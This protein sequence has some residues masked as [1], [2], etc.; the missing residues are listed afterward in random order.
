MR[1]VTSFLILMA[2]LYG[3]AGNF[4]I[5]V[6]NP[7]ELNLALLDIPSGC[8]TLS[9]TG[10]LN[11]ADLQLLH[12]GYGMLKSIHTLDVSGI[13]CIENEED[14][15]LTVNRVRYFFSSKEY[16]ELITEESN[17]WLVHDN[18]YT[19]YY[20]RSL[21][22]VFAIDAPYKEVI[23]PAYCNATKSAFYENTNIE[24]ISYTVAPTKVEDYAFYGCSALKNVNV[25][26]ELSE[27]GERAFMA[28]ENVIL[29]KL[30]PSVVGREA[31]AEANVTDM[32]FSK[33]LKLDDGAFMKSNL[34][35]EI[36]LSNI[37]TIP[38][39]CFKFAYNI[40]GVK[41]SPSLKW[42]DRE[43]LYGVNLGI[44]EFPE[45]LEYLGAQ[46][47]GDY[48]TRE[49]KLKPEDGIYYVANVAYALDFETLPTNIVIKAG[50]KAI[51]GDLFSGNWATEKAI[52]SVKLPEGLKHIGERAFDYAKSL[53]TIN[54]PE[55]LVGIYDEAFSSADKLMTPAFPS[56]LR[57]IGSR[58][59]QNCQMIT[60]LTLPSSIETIGDYAFEGCNGI[61]R[62]YFDIMD[63]SNCEFLLAGE[64]L[65]KLIIGPNA[66][67]LPPVNAPNLLV[68]DSE[69]RG[70]DAPSFEMTCFLS[71]KLRSVILPSTT[72]SF[73][74]SIFA[75]CN[76]L[77]SVSF[78]GMNTA[79]EFIIGD[80][81]FI[82][83][84]KL[85]SIEL[86]ESTIEIGDYA[87]YKSGLKSVTLPSK[88]RKLGEEPFGGCL[89][90][91]DMFVIPSSLEEYAPAG[92][93]ASG[94]FCGMLVKNITVPETL[95]GK[96][97]DFH[98]LPNINSIIFE[99]GAE[100]LD[101]SIYDCDYMEL[102]M[103]K[104]LREIRGEITNNKIGSL[105]VPDGVERF[106]IFSGTNLTEVSLPASCLSIE[107][108]DG[109]PYS[110]NVSWRIHEGNNFYEGA[111]NNAIKRLHGC[112]G[113][114]II[115]EGVGILGDEDNSNISVMTDGDLSKI[116]IPSTVFKINSKAFYGCVYPEIICYAV[117]P[118]EIFGYCEYL[119]KN[120]INSI[121]LRGDLFVPEES[122]EKYKNSGFKY[123]NIHPLE[124]ASI[125]NIECEQ[126]E[127]AGDV[128]NMQGIPLI[129][130]A[131][132][133]DLNQLPSGIYIFA[134]KKI[135]IK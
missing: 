86:P 62:V 16:S 29:P 77:T 128:Y 94:S 40:T 102:V 78:N 55:G 38:A 135:L 43:A 47:V 42:I 83:T 65:Q 21:G 89:G 104:G 87:F 26:T 37:D 54:F 22:G 116:V 48:H 123:F 1:I 28:C 117:N 121:Y 51:S 63:A 99:G 72:I 39:N 101:L 59:F 109:K 45:S 20:T 91:Q 3:F 95:A 115:P 82:E 88:L 131:T 56:T 44:T 32:D 10:T 2:S 12:S 52:K 73:P 31:F 74:E 36:D 118:P 100:I 25:S 24:K 97:I 127:D 70:A 33:V 67:F 41:F 68:I 71:S 124:S 107:C 129:Y 90:E 14:P 108:I 17:P 64:G 75:Y 106:G 60:E 133:D 19:Y 132:K 85:H 113:T 114:L 57:H 84:G 126:V 30:S 103:P 66:S 119:V 120:N 23:L 58:A 105:Y 53:E 50:T 27:I 76:D 7:G 35:G 18:G 125:D 46:A 79:K 49:L 130:N 8:E 80:N 134:G 4:S 5:E 112:S 92:F 13:Q 61:A 122:V 96:R 81:A 9:I 34:T 11:N 69:E 111:D 110:M 98:N 15:Y 93:R 6:K